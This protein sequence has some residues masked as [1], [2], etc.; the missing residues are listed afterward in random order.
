MGPYSF[1]NFQGKQTY[2]YFISKLGFFSSHFTILCKN[3]I[4]MHRLSDVLC[5]FINIVK[6]SHR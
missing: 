2:V 6:K 4:N 5:F 1:R 3:I